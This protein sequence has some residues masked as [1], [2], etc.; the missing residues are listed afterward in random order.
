MLALAGRCLSTIKARTRHSATLRRQ[1]EA[2]RLFQRLNQLSFY[3][4]MLYFF[5][6]GL[7]MRGTE[8]KY[9]GPATVTAHS[10]ETVTPVLDLF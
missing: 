6:S 5:T 8:P 4:R 9:C 10:L 7:D 2:L 1:V 3:E